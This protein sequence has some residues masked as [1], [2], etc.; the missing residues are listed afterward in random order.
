MSEIKWIDVTYCSRGDKVRPPTSWATEIG[1]LR[2]TVTS[3]NIDYPGKWV[4]HCTQCGI[5]TVPVL[6]VSAD[7][8]QRKAVKM[9]RER[10]AAWHE[11]LQSTRTAE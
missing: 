8:A 2:I 1:G 10:V 7:N 9:V 11:A 5:D 6:A 3:S 4:M